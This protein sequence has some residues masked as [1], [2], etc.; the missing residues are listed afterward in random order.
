MP[1]EDEFYRERKEREPSIEVP[2][3]YLRW[4]S[5]PKAQERNSPEVKKDWV[6][7]NFSERELEA[8]RR[9]HI[10]IRLNN[11]LVAAGVIKK[12]SIKASNRMQESMI[13][14]I[15]ATSVG[16]KGFGRSL[17]TTLIQLKHHKI[18]DERKKGFSFRRRKE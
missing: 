1:Q 16:F 5:N 4:R 2:E 11:A 13:D 6:L 17:D 14:G 15:A 8:S 12:K 7:A 10:L 9:K 18:E 3:E